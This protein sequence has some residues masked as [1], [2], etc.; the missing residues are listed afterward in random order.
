MAT[1][2]L[3]ERVAGP[4]T[5]DS[6]LRCTGCSRLQDGADVACDL[7]VQLGEQVSVA[8]QGHVDRRVAHPALD[9]L[10]MG[11]LGDRERD[12]S[13]PQVMLKPMSA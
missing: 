8:V 6:A 9:C 5:A 4:N 1:S 10:G 7:A 12:R 3:S 11:S 13:V 2:R